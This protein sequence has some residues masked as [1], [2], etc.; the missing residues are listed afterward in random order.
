VSTKAFC[1]IVLGRRKIMWEK[2]TFV[3]E[4]YACLILGKIKCLEDPIN[5]FWKENLLKYGR[6]DSFNNQRNLP[7][8]FSLYSYYP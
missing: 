7:N 4:K 2:P 8:S 3:W 6:M 5:A 1:L